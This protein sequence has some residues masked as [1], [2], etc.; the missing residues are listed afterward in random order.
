MR[1]FI[2]TVVGQK[3]DYK[4][5]LVLVVLV[6]LEVPVAVEKRRLTALGGG[7]VVARGGVVV[8]AVDHG[9]IL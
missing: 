5:S 3:T 4:N 6:V 8:F 2:I 1:A 7:V 9:E